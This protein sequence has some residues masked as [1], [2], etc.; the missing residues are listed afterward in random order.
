MISL[1]SYP[2]SFMRFGDKKIVNDFFADVELEVGKDARIWAHPAVF[3]N[4]LIYTILKFIFNI[5]SLSAPIP[6]GAFAPV[7]VLGAGF[8][9]TYGY[10]LKKIGIYFGYNLVKC[11]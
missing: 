10:I 8:G 9:R 4:L 3:F 6:A 7:F 1:I 5:F 11:K 2:V